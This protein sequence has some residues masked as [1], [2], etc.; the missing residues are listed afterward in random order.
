MR[1]FALLGVFCSNKSIYK[2]SEEL[3]NGVHL[4]CT[5]KKFYCTRYVTNPSAL[6]VRELW[7]DAR[8]VN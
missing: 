8:T 6:V 5:D 4:A 1:L 7:E 3:L 2:F